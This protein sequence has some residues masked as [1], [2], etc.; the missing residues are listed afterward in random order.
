MKD[1]QK[2]KYMGTKVAVYFELRREYTKEKVET[3]SS[4]TSRILERDGVVWAPFKLDK[5]RSGWIVGFRSVQEG[6]FDYTPYDEEGGQVPYL[7][8]IGRVQAVQVC[9]WPTMKPVLVPMDGFDSVDHG[10]PVSP[11][12]WAWDGYCGDTQRRVKEIMKGYSGPDYR[13]PDTGRFKK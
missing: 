3:R 6:H 12:K 7:H 10:E 9:Y 4:L 5:P 8:Q 2:V 11:A 13:D 1:K